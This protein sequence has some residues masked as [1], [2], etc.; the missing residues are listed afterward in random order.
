MK[1]YHVTGLL[2][3]FL[4]LETS[5]KSQQITSAQIG[6]KGGLNV[7]DMSVDKWD[8]RNMKAGLHAGLYLKFPFISRLSLQPEILYSRKGVK[9]SFAGELPEFEMIPDESVLSLDYFELTMML[10]YQVYRGLNLHLGPY[11]GFLIDADIETRENLPEL[12]GFENISQ[13]AR[14]NFIQ[15]D[16][17]LSAGLELDFWSYKFG[18]RYSHGFTRVAQRNDVTYLL[19]GNAKNMVTQVYIAIRF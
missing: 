18:F 2:V 17:G 9:F 10:A 1:I 5:L 3:L 13:V 12:P 15:R 19:L 8:D 16:I 6:I 11:T 14:R 4:G 7:T